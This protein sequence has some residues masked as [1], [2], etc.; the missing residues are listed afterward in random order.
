MGRA[1][2]T[3]IFDTPAL[4]KLFE[5]F[6]VFTCLVIHRIGNQGTQVWFGTADQDMSYKSVHSQVDA[7]VIGCGILTC[8]TI[9]TLT[10]LLSY[11]VEGREVV[12]ATVRPRLL[13]HRLHAADDGRRHGLSHLQQCVRTLRP[14]V[15]ANQ[16]ISR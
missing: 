1:S 10:I 16:N 12:Q 3:H 11:L 14:P 2:M 4:F 7:E 13:L 8:M 15:V 9:V 6:G 5:A